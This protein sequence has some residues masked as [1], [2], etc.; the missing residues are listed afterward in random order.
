MAKFKID[1]EIDWLGEDG[2]LDDEIKD[3]IKNQIV[4]KI[5]K[6]VMSD[7]RDTAIQAAESRIGIWIN[8]FI[9]QLSSEKAIPYKEHSYD[10]EVKMVTIEELLGKKFEEAL[11]QI[12]DKDGRP[13]SS[14][15]DRYGT[16]LDWITGKQARIYADERVKEFIKD[17]KDDIESYTSKKVKEEMMKQLTAS[18]ISNIDFNKVFKE[19]A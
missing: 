7:I 9:Q 15:Y 13:T 3:S 16:R 10:R 12:V 5:E 6:T 2:A 1:V 18:L 19:E 8:R 14:S 17:I 4:E 11:N